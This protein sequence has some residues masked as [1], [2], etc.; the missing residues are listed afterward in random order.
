MVATTRSKR[1]GI[2]RACSGDTPTALEKVLDFTE[3]DFEFTTTKNITNILDRGILKEFRR[4]DDEPVTFSFSAKFRDRTIHEVLDKFVWD[5]QT[6]LITGLTDGANNVGVATTLGE[7][8]EQ[9]TLFITDPGFTKLAAGVTPTSAGEYSEDVGA[10]DEEGVIVATTFEVFP[11]V[12]DTDVNISYGAVGT[13]TTPDSACSDVKTL[14]LKF[15][16]VNPCDPQGGANVEFTYEFEFAA[17][18]S[19]T[20]AEGD[21]FDTVSFE[22]VARQIR[23]TVTPPQGTP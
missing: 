21:E 4:G 23:P 20:V 22:G 7:G 14:K 16:L 5:G 15:D 3:G 8:Y 13:S 11:P 9:G 6:E 18:T 1:H 19:F 12:A 2:L 10:A 17:L